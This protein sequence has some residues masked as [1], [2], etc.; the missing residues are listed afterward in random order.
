MSNNVLD[1]DN[2]LMLLKRSCFI[3]DMIRYGSGLKYTYGAWNRSFI[4]CPLV[5]P[6]DSDVTES[7]LMPSAHWATVVIMFSYIDRDAPTDWHALTCHL[8]RESNTVGGFWWETRDS[9]IGIIQLQ[10]QLSQDSATD[11]PLMG[12]AVATILDSMMDVN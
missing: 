6:L 12:E 3:Y 9:I 11:T 5:L 7:H 1:L 8:Y 4:Y 2:S 10:L